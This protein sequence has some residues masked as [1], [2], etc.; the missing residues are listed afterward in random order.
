MAV[1]VPILVQTI[2][3]ISKPCHPT[4]AD[5]TGKLVEIKPKYRTD[6]RDLLGEADIY[7]TCEFVT[8]AKTIRLWATRMPALDVDVI[9]TVTP[10]AENFKQG[11]Y[12]A[13]SADRGVLSAVLDMTY[14]IG[15]YFYSDS[16]GSID[17]VKA[18]FNRFSKDTDWQPV[19]GQVLVGVNPQDGDF[20]TSR[21]MG[22]NKYHIHGFSFSMGSGST[23]QPTL[24]TN[25]D[26]V[27]IGLGLGS[28]ATDGNVGWTGWSEATSGSV[29][30]YNN[31]VPNIATTQH[32]S[33]ANGST[34][35]AST[36][37]PYVTTY[38]WRRIK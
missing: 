6:Q 8:D 17:A 13:T 31:S 18:H 24:Y 14:P 2:C 15:S 22:G 32:K 20:N 25:S 27:D 37:Q 21:K 34:A 23:V 12:V 38:I 7:P 16:L 4:N 35:R 28:V 9:V 33:Y 29:L 10:N 19:L 11:T 30:V 26:I 36:L 5:F 1:S 3:S